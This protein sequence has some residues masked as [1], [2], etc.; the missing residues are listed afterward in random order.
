MLSV[1]GRRKVFRSGNS[2]VVALPKEALEWLGLAEGVE[3]AIEV[4]RERGKIILTPAPPA[5][6]PPAPVDA[7][8][9][10]KVDGFI[11]RYR[12]ALEALARQ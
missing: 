9:A 12:P 11:Q 3:L 6:A 5:A 10:R 4:D 1:A 2:L 8:F 7:E